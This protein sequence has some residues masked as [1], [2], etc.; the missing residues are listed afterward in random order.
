MRGGGDDDDDD[1]VSFAAKRALDWIKS[2]ISQVSTDVS[3]TLGTP[4]RCFVSF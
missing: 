4:R 2:S 1:S 3:T